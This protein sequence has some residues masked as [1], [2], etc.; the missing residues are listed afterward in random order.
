M[1]SAAVTT[2]QTTEFSKSETNSFNAVKPSLKETQLNGYFFD[3]K[4][5]QD[6]HRLSRPLPSEFADLKHS[7]IYEVVD[8]ETKE[9][10][11]VEVA[12]DGVFSKFNYL[13]EIMNAYKEF[14]EPNLEEA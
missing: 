11:K 12:T 4:E 10:Y 9:S 14:R 7:E 1:A 5:D 3:K 2:S 13:V 6:G 8:Q